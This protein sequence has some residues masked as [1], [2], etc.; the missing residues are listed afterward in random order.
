MESNEPLKPKSRTGTLLHVACLSALL[1]GCAP[2]MTQ[3]T[4]G[5]SRTNTGQPYPQATSFNDHVGPNF[6]PYVY[7][8]A[9]Q[10][11]FRQQTMDSDNKL[12]TSGMSIALEA[13]NA[14][15]LTCIFDTPFE[16]DAAGNLKPKTVTLEIGAGLSSVHAHG[17]GFTPMEVEASGGSIYIAHI[18]VNQVP[19]LEWR[20]PDTHSSL[21]AFNPGVGAFCDMRTEST[22]PSPVVC[23]SKLQYGKPS[24]DM[25]GATAICAPNIQA[26]V[27][28]Y[29]Q[30]AV[31]NE[32]DENRPTS[33]WHRICATRRAMFPVPCAT[34]DPLPRQESGQ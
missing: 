21:G 22:K 15:K 20:D 34:Y 8:G 3:N 30:M 29:K 18:G 4:S 33:D 31:W 17:K 10:E 12:V 26:A 7:G 1:S 25:T 28:L 23:N 9:G 11:V 27:H 6:R 16:K 32:P 24:F 5:W 13:Q 2:P 19:L 14:Q